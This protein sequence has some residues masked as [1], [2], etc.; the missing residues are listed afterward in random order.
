MSAVIETDSRLNAFFADGVDVLPDDHY[1][2]HDIECD[3]CGAAEEADVAEDVDQTSVSSTTVVQTKACISPHV[4]HKLCL[5]TWLD[6]NLRQ[7]QDATCPM[8]RHKLILIKTSLKFDKLL[9]VSR[10]D[11]TGQRL[12]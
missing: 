4:F 1:V 2:A 6:S 3:I 11:C 8:Y 12:H 10:V 5:Y 7:D 9:T